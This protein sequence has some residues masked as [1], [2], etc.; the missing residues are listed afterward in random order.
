MK[1]APL[2]LLLPRGAAVAPC[3]PPCAALMRAVGPVAA[4]LGA[5]EVRLCTHSSDGGRSCWSG[6]L[7]FQEFSQTLPG[8]LLLHRG[9]PSESGASRG[10][11]ELV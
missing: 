5:C 10:G 4:P 6:S 11:E 8:E 9:E 1:S 7:A 3:L 2:A